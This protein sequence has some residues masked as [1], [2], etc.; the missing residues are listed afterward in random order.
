MHLTIPKKFRKSFQN[1]MA[2][3]PSRS[4]DRETGRQDRERSADDDRQHARKRPVAAPEPASVAMK[5]SR[6][7][8]TPHVSRGPTTPPR[9]SHTAMSRVNSNNSTAH[10]PGEPMRR[11]PS[12]TGA[13]EKR[14]NGVASVKLDENDLRTKEARVR[15]LGTRLKH[16]ADAAFGIV[17]L[18]SGASNTKDSRPRSASDDRSSRDPKLG[19]ILGVESILSFMQVFHAH[20]TRVTRRGEK[21]DGKNWSDLLAVARA[22][23]TMAHQQ[24]AQR[25]RPAFA[26]LLIL[27]V[28]VSDEVTKCSIASDPG[29]DPLK[30]AFQTRS[31][32]LRQIREIYAPVDNYRLRAEFSPWSTLDDVTDTI[33]RVMKR[34]CAEEDVNWSPELA[35]RDYGR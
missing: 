21:P 20:D 14:P 18:S 32:L 12:A 9:K 33:V 1:I 4:R 30:A 22:F 3:P 19:M 7:S 25:H 11:T 31:Q 5:K 6:S 29:P 27:Q 35:P 13:G 26:L 8:D 16:R 15:E 23:C 10:T 24:G 17:R 2:P 34:W 28:V